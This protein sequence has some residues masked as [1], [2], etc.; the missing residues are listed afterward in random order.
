MYRLEPS[1]PI[2]KRAHGFEVGDD[3]A[4][5]STSTI[6][7]AAIHVLQ[8]DLMKM[9]TSEEDTFISS[10]WFNLAEV[11]SII[12][13]TK[14]GSFA[15]SKKDKAWGQTGYRFPYL[16]FVD[17]I[18]QRV[19]IDV[20]KGNKSAFIS[21]AEGKAAF[22]RSRMVTRP[23]VMAK[24]QIGNFF[25]DGNLNTARSRE[26]KYMPTFTGGTGIPAPFEVPENILLYMYSY[27]GGA[28][29]RLYA[30]G[31]KEARDALYSM[32]TRGQPRA[33]HLCSALRLKTDYLMATYDDKVAVPKDVTLPSELPPPTYQKLAP[34]NASAVVEASL[35]R[36]K[37]LMTKDIAEVELMRLKRAVNIF[38]GSMS[39]LN[40][41]KLE[42]QARAE[43]R[44]EFGQALNANSAFLNLIS[45]D[46][47][48]ED[49][50]QLM[51]DGFNVVQSL[52]RQFDMED[53]NWV[54]NGCRGSVTDPRQ[55]LNT[56]LASSMSNWRLS[57]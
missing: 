13:R 10:E 37:V 27:K 6:E 52:K 56:Q 38:Y 42:A 25:Q 50:R 30:S 24:T 48:P 29:Q 1:M 44:K 33:L 31:L 26:P 16:E 53:A 11:T 46:A 40:H 9:S 54:F 51:K 34:G 23:E 15:R 12:P 47:C 20:K 36:A 21:G 22:L 45:R 18:P 3:R 28:Y 57:D 41:E 43:G 14:Q 5:W 55:P 39:V 19:M 17:D 2:G 8:E 32:D 4:T 35:V 7:L 49:M